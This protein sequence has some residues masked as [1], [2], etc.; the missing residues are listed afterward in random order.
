MNKGFKLKATD[1]LYFINKIAHAISTDE[2]R[3][4]LNGIFLQQT[5]NKLRAVA[6]NGYTFALIESDRLDSP[7]DELGKG[8]II[9]RKGVGELKKLAEQ[10][11]DSTLEISVDESFM[12]VSSSDQYQISIRLIARDYPPYQTVIPSETSYSMTVSRDHLLDA[13]RRIKVLAN[14]KSNAIKFSMDKEKLTVSANH[15]SL[16]EATEKIDVDYTGKS[17]NIGFNARYMMDSLSVLEDD[18]VTLEFNN[19]LGP[20]IVKSQKLQEFLGIVMPLKL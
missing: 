13:I 19:E 1:V 10:D 6:T 5:E 12:Y 8:I 2:T 14:E 11:R 16:G 15:P 18:D 4:F 3:I 20:V 9:P 7:S 17:I